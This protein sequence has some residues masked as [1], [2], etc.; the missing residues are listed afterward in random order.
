MNGEE[1]SSV[2]VCTMDDDD[3]NHEELDGNFL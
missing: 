1:W 3:G 2:L